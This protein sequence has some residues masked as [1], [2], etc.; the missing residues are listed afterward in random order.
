MRK[1]LRLFKYVRSRLIPYLKWK[2]LHSRRKHRRFLHLYISGVHKFKLR[3]LR[4]RFFR[5]KYKART[6]AKKRL[7]R[8]TFYKPYLHPRPALY[9][10]HNSFNINKETLYSMIL[11]L[12]IAQRLV[13]HTKFRIKNMLDFYLTLKRRL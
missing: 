9:N 3:R 2:L 11:N 1:L 8:L 12:F 7:T 6:R 13:T 4:K 5:L 10:M